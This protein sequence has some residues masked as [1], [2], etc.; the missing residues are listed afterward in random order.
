MTVSS[1][2]QPDLASTAPARTGGFPVTI[3]K[4]EP[5]GTAGEASTPHPVRVDRHGTPIGSLPAWPAPAHPY[6]A[7]TERQPITMPEPISAPTGPVANERETEELA[8][9][10]GIRRVF[11]FGYQN[12]FLDAVSVAEL[13]SRLVFLFRLLRPDIVMTFNPAQPAEQN[14]DHWVTGQAVEAARWMAGL[15]KD[16]PEHLS[17][18]LAPHII[19]GRM[20]WVARA[21][22][23]TNRIVDVSG[24]VDT[25]VES[26]AVHQVQGTAGS[27]GR[28]LR[29]TLAERGLVIPEL[30]DD[31]DTADR[32]Y[33]RRF[34]LASGIELGARHGMACAE[35]FY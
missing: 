12:H 9:I 35:P 23:P 7:P 11:N 29:A 14:P 20:Y 28:R 15:D 3:W 32:A 26:L 13:R 2:M 10:L 31:D 25:K 30:G 22:Q 24:Y 1:T 5:A 27:T 21:G 33:I 19:R 18:G 6:T 16:Y 4:H 8:R 17:A 34:M